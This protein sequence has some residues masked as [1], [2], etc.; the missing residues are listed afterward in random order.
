[1][2]EYRGILQQVTEQLTEDERRQL[3]TELIADLQAG[4]G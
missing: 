4:S 3:L 1:L 2:E